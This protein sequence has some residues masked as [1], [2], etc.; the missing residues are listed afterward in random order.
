[1]SL[2]F[3]CAKYRR[4]EIKNIEKVPYWSLDKKNPSHVEDF[5]CVAWI[6]LRLLYRIDDFY[7]FLT[8]LN[9]G[10]D[11]GLN[12][13]GRPLGLFRVFGGFAGVPNP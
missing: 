12:P 4:N 2:Y 11:L 5:Y 1:M 3:S 8:T 13:C 10:R 6:A 9:L 7:V